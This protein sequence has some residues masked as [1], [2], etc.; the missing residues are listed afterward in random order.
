MN[1]LPKKGSSPLPGIKSVQSIAAE[2][3]EAVVE[4]AKPASKRLGVAERMRA[5]NA[6]RMAPDE[7]SSDMF[8]LPQELRDELDAQGLS[9]EF[10]AVSVMGKEES[11]GY[12]MRIEQGGW[13]PFR[14]EDFPRFKY[15]QPKDAPTDMYE[16]GGQRLYIRL[17]ELTEQA[18]A[19][20]KRQADLRVQNILPRLQD[21]PLAAGRI[22]PMQHGD[23]AGI[24][25][26]YERA[27]E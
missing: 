3:D 23:V 16:V 13:E 11:P 8:F 26:T 12:F 5:R 9:F 15:M 14:M 18:R 19:D 22:K 24:R 21:T 17:K 20:D 2:R 25:R 4:A 10:K 27:V 1:D 7:D 6:Q